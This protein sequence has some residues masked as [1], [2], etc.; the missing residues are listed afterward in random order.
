MKQLAENLYK[1]LLNFLAFEQFLP[2]SSLCVFKRFSYDCKLGTNVFVFS[3][4]FLL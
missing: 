3:T 2:D 4:D 1:H